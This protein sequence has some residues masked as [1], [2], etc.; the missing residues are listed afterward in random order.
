MVLNKKQS[1]ELETLIANM[2]P[3]QFKALHIDICNKLY[4]EMDLEELTE[5]RDKLNGLIETAQET[6]R[7]KFLAEAREWSEKARQMGLD[8][9]TALGVAAPSKRSKPANGVASGANLSTDGRSS[10]EVQ[11]RNPK[12]H[13]EDWKLRGQKPRWLIRELATRGMDADK[14]KNSEIPAEYW[15]KNQ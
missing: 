11:I 4:A 13:S 7:E 9:G 8:L 6:K 5:A 1:G 10:P 14:I 15:V 3:D 12:N 2:S